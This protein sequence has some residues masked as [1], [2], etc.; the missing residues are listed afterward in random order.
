MVLNLAEHL[1]FFTVRNEGNGHSNTT[2]TT[3]TTDTVKVGLEVGCV[4]TLAGIEL[5]GDILKKD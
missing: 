2:K 3:S 5:L 4:C 1:P